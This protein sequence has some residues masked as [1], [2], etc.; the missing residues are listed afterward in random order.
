MRNPS[1]EA[2][3]GHLERYGKDGIMESANHLP[4][5]ERAELQKAVSKHGKKVKK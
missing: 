5:E 4:D 1:L 3:L 2:L